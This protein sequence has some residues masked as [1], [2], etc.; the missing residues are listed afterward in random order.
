MVLVDNGDATVAT[1]AKRLSGSAGPGGV[2]LITHQHR[3]L[4][5]EVASMGLKQI[6]REFEDWM[7]NSRPTWEAFMALIL[8]ASLAL[9]SA[10]R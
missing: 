8:G 6:V 5:F 3:M 7:I 1:V 10:M 2:D 9:I 4:R